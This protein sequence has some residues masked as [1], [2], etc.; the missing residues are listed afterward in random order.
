[1]TF[2]AASLSVDVLEGAAVPPG[3][4]LAGL[5]PGCEMHQTILE[6]HPEMD[7]AQAQS[8]VVRAAMQ[9]VDRH[10]RLRHIV[11]ECA[12]MPPYRQAVAQAT[13]RTV[14]DLETLLLDRI[15]KGCT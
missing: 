2:D 13:G 8:D 12:N 5:E 9:L 11:L 4:P 3:T 7:L 1:L 14:H 6:D 10:P 15:S